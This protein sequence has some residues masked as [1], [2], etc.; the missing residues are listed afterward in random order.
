ME[1][2]TPGAAE[3]AP[4][5]WRPW[6]WKLHAQVFTGLF[7]GALVGL[8]L[9]MWAVGQIPGEAAPAARGVA[10]GAL[11]RDHALFAIL[12]L[13]GDLFLNALFAITIPLITTSILLAVTRIGGNRDFGRLGGKTLGYYLATSA[14][15]IVTGLVLVNLFTPGLTDSGAGILEG[16]D[17]SAFQGEQGEVAKKVAGRGLADFLDIFRS[18]VP[19]NLVA[20]AGAGNFIGLIVASIVAGFFLGRIAPE[21]RAA[22]ENVIQAIYDLT[23]LVTDLVLRLAPIGVLALIA[24]TFAEQYATLW[25]D[26]RFASFITGIVTFAAVALAALLVHFLVTLPLILYLVARVSPL[27]HYRAMAPALVTAFSTASSSATL[28]VTIECV[29]KRAGVSPRIAGFT[30]PIG[31]TVNMDGTAL[32]EC[33]AAVFICQAFGVEL[34]LTQQLLIVVVAL[35]TSVGVAGVPSASL[36]AIAVILRT[37]QGQLP[38]GAEV[39]LVLG[40]G[41]L[42]VFDR[43]LDMARTAVNMF[44]DSVGA[45]TIARSERE[46]TLIARE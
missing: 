30:L 9:G 22:L 44:S 10:G 46:R 40:M 34:S 4:A 14:I 24:C 26:A 35:L 6:R 28:P 20:A 11:V 45:V 1:D 37:V 21:R 12:D 19:S 2:A 36:V 8:V 13:L 16:Q 23:I 27:A 5:R 42:F 25:P 18:M 29:E 15:A 3:P 39:D 41:L 38:P 31:A 17:L 33:V 43:P 7:A 32:Y